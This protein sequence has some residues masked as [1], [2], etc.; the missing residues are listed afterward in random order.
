MGTKRIAIKI[1]SNVLTQKNGKLDLN[2]L[3]ALVDQLVCLNQAGL[4]VILISS[5]A[6]AS[7]RSEITPKTKLDPVEARQLFS[8]VGQ[9]KLINHYYTLFAKKG[10]RCGQV[11]TTKENFRSRQ[12]FLT[13]KQCLTTMLENGVIPIL[14]E[15]D[16]ISVTELMFTD[17]DE[18]SGLV[19][20]MMTVEQL[21]ILSNVDGI[22][23]GDPSV[24]GSEL[25]R[26]ISSDK[27]DLSQYISTQKSNFGRGGML[28]KSS[29]AQKVAKGGIAVRIANGTRENVLVDLLLH[30]NDIP[31]TL[32]EPESRSV[33]SV[34]KW[35]GASQGFSKGALMLNA[36]AVSAILSPKATSVLP[37][38]VIEVKGEF[39]AGDIVEI[40]SADGEL[41]G[42]GKAECSSESARASMGM[43]GQKPVVHYDYLYLYES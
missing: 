16:T 43:H 3:S 30:H 28:T 42:L 2:R 5:G 9:A 40:R 38:G 17:N 20:E 31:C 24:E 33:S 7:G 13:M 39:M 14:N 41:L 1:G 34:K 10:L 12:H 22:Y 4:E 18:L 29:I 23:T 15:N 26:I 32:F 21:I 6:V 8:A 25:L 11:L 35:I 36:G 37:V 19:S 27:K